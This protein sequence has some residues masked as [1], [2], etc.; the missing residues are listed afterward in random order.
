MYK[1]EK[2]N[3]KK[4][5]GN[6][7][8]RKRVFEIDLKNIYDMKNI[9]NNGVN[10]IDEINLL[11]YIL[12]PST[13][14]KNINYNYSPILHG[15]INT[16]RVRGKYILLRILLDTG[17]SYTI[18]TRKLMLKLKNTKYSIMQWKTQAA[19][20][21]S[22][23]KSKIHFTFHETSATVTWNYHVDDSA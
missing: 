19:N 8:W 22:N 7:E 9:Q 5:N 15:C 4:E 23:H 13:R 2:M 18:V 3:L 20:T 17:Y 6:K 12:N 10:N 1:K 14:S 16:H 11:H 21:S